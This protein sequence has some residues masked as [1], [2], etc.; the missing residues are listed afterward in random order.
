MASPPHPALRATFSPLGRRGRPGRPAQSRLFACNPPP[1]H[2]ILGL[3]PRIHAKPPPAPA[4]RADHR[5]VG[6]GSAPSP[7]R[8][9]LLCGPSRS[10]SSPQRGEG[11]PKG[12]M[13]GRSHSIGRISPPH[14]L[15]C[16]RHFSP[17]GRSRNRQTQCF[18][19]GG[20]SPS[21]KKI[22]PVHPR[23]LLLCQ[24]AMVLSRIHRKTLAARQG[25]RST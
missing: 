20:F 5:L 10:P 1:P 21:R 11:G 25:W 7:G 8:C 6:N 23:P 22:I 19:R 12:R 16:A 9:L 2:V 13:R 4:F 17:L 15:A 24:D 14:R 18:R 3:D